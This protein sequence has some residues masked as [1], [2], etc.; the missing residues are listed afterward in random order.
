MQAEKLMQVKDAVLKLR[1]QL[2]AGQI[3]QSLP[4][5][6]AT[7]IKQLPSTVTTT[8]TIPSDEE[9]LPLIATLHEQLKKAR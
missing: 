5:R 7:L 8:V 3:Y 9:V 2:R 4:S 6:M 1:Q